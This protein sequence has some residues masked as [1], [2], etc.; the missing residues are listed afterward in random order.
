M[1]RALAMILAP[2][3]L[4]WTG[5][6]TGLEE[7]G[8]ADPLMVPLWFEWVAGSSLWLSRMDDSLARR[9]L[10]RADGSPL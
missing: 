7:A 9:P 8:V 6:W 1:D 4:D 3:R 10:V 2:V 5:T